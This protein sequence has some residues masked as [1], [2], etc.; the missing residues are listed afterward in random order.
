MIR[1]V[2]LGSQVWRTLTPRSCFGVSKQKLNFLHK[3]PRAGVLSAMPG[4]MR[5]LIKS[6]RAAS[7]KLKPISPSRGS[8]ELQPRT[9]GRILRSWA[10]PWD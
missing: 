6:G 4:I 2:E 7:F 3:V 9:G 5:L 1:H 8:L 10:E